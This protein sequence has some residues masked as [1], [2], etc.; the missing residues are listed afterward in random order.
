MPCHTYGVTSPPDSILPSHI[1]TSSKSMPAALSSK[2]SNTLLSAASQNTQTFAFLL[3]SNGPRLA[4]CGGTSVAASHAYKVH[5]RPHRAH[6]LA[7]LP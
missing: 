3:A 4:E 1:R 2:A 6:G 5:D 7:P